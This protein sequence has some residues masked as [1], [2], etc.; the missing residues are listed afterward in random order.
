M[1]V[2]H[3]WFGHYNRT[4]PR[5]RPELLRSWLIGEAVLWDS[6]HGAEALQL[7]T[8]NREGLAVARL[9]SNEPRKSL[10]RLLAEMRAFIPGE[11]QPP[12]ELEW[13]LPEVG[14]SS[15]RPG[16]Q[17]PLGDQSPDDGEGDPGKRSDEGGLSGATWSISRSGASRPA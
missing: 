10:R 3:G 14:P 15:P 17:G 7:L 11:H 13:P 2:P 9:T 6:K 12:R 16:P 8:D 1:G 5:S 4:H